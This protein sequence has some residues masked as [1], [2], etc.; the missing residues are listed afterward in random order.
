MTDERS[1]P[2]LRAIH[3]V[4]VPVSDVDVARAWYSEV[5]G[6]EPVLDYEEED[7]IVGV[8]LAG[9]GGITVGLHL[10]P[11][12]ARALAGFCVL[13]LEVRDQGALAAWVE[14]LDALGIA[15]SGIREGHLGLHL[16]TAD[17]DGVVVQLHTAEHPSADE[18]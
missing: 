5:L 9:R 18:E 3:H 16:E 14:H 12:R 15:H 13:A 6:L 8:S 7:R 4:R 1:A 11:V 2:A 10:D 17:P